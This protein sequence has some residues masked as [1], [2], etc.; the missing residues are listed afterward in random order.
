MTFKR[1]KNL[2]S[3]RGIMINDDETIFVSWQAMEVH[4]NI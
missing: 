1:K 3:L 2:F 4:Q